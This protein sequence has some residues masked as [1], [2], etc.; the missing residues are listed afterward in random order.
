METQLTF[1]YDELEYLVDGLAL[2][3][4]ATDR[5]YS[6]AD[7]D[8]MRELRDQI[9]RAMN[10]YPTPSPLPPRPNYTGNTGHAEDCCCLMCHAR[11]LA[12]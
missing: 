12:F 10:D 5:G 6:N 9:K 3:R 1:T 7:R 4:R 2:L 8:R 11:R